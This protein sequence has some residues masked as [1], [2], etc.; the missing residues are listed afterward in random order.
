MHLILSFNVLFIDD[1]YQEYK[2]RAVTEPLDLETDQYLSQ[3]SDPAKDLLRQM[4]E[5]NPRNRPTIEQVLAH[6]WL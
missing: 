5:K 3:L 4:L 2:Y 1:D 6:E